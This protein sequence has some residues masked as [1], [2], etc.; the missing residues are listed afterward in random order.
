[1]GLRVFDIGDSHES[2]DYERLHYQQTMWDVPT[3]SEKTTEKALQP[4]QMGRPRTPTEVARRNRVVTL[5]TDSEFEQ[6]KTVAAV[7][8]RSVSAVVHQVISQFLQRR[9]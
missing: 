1:M 7:T 4:R 3:M 2:I 9:Q 5:V 8:E 6:L